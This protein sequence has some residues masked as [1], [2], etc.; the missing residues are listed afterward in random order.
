MPGLTQNADNIED[1]DYSDIE[2]KYKVDYD[3]SFD[4]TLIVDGVPI[5]DNSK[6]ERLLTKICKE[7]SRKGVPVKQD[8]IFIPWDEATGK[9]KGYLFMD[10]RNAHDA[11]NALLAMNNHPFDAK[12]VFK[13]NRFDEIEKYANMDETY[14]EPEQ[15]EYMPREHLRAWLTDPQGRD[16]YVVYRGDDV[17]IFWHGKPS[18][19]ELAYKP[20]WKDF[21]YVSWSPL[22]TY[23][24]TLHRQGVRLWG[25][26]SWK[27]QQR[28]AHPL[29]KLIDF[30][31]CENYIV[32]WSNES[33][34]VPD[35]KPQ[36]PQYFSPEDEG[37]NLAVWDIKTGHLLRTFPTNSGTEGPAGKRQM[38]W[39]ALKW[40]PDDKFVARVSPGQ[41]ISVHEL[42]SMFLHEKKSLK[43]EGVVDFEWC[44]LSDKDRDE[45]E[46]VASVGAKGAKKA[47]ENMIAYWTPEVANQPARVTLLSF[48]GRTI[49]RQKNLF[50]V[51]E[52]KLHWQNQ[53]DFLCVKV[54]RHTKTKKSI[55]CNLEI[56]RV[57]EKDFPVEVV[58]LKDTVTDFS[59]E[60][61]GERFAIVST[62]DPN[63][64]NPGPGI[65]I[66]TDVSFYQLDRVKNDFKLLKTLPNRTSNAIRWSPRGRFVVLA[67]V[68]SSTKS[69]LEFWDLDFTLEDRR[70]GQVVKE[71]WGSSIQSL[72]IADHYGVTDV[73][74][75]PSGRYLATSASAWT[76]TLENGY[77]LWDFR[78]QELLKQIQDR[79]KQFLWRPR[80]R[81]LLTREQQKQIRKNLKEFSRVFEEED[82]RESENVNTEL[83][84][85]RRRLVDEWNAWRARSTKELAEDKGHDHVKEKQS[86]EDKEEIEVWV[87]DIIEQI[88]EEVED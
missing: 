55:F 62:N 52:C 81:T 70:D 35:G 57:R 37:N 65:T 10:F 48:P 2:A 71:D 82:Q 17:E 14:V 86:E 32:T 25:G 73:E 78:G 76:H 27:P 41:M 29:V 12:H 47:P 9:S 44:P 3:G 18:Q 61:K 43:I 58:E 6:L 4:N 38:Q 74:W 15:E 21:L 40:S 64:G 59:W 42:P 33:I 1:I 67:T 50:N 88:E 80:P 39:P 13:L 7:F 30:S 36:G 19:C 72:G 24:A 22:G 66:K 46:K 63:L 23:I 77:A 69:E 51:S 11:N 56:F 31:P 28:F 49:L 68:G 20:D 54:D 34:I 75:D 8:D 84:A 26:P 60:P 53:G 5:I 45:V 79:F 83:L 16:Q 85:L 87:E